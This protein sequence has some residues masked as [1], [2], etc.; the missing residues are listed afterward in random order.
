MKT[1]IIYH[2]KRGKIRFPERYS[3]RER[4]YASLPRCDAC[5]GFPKTNNHLSQLV[6][7]LSLGLVAVRDGAPTSFARQVRITLCYTFC[8][9]KKHC[10]RLHSFPN[11]RSL[12]CT[13]YEH[14]TRTQVVRRV[15]MTYRSPWRTTFLDGCRFRSKRLRKRKQQRWNIE[16]TTVRQL[17]EMM[18]DVSMTSID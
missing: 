7:V 5:L 3:H 6:A 9:C 16:G 18:S 1:L 8:I 2:T 15:Q 11:V 14:T 12:R 13:V 4:L 17:G 10:A